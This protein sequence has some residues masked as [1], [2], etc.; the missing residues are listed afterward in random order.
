MIDPQHLKECILALTPADGGSVGN[1]RLFAALQREFPSLQE[2]EYHAAREALVSAGLLLKGKGRGGSVLR[3]PAAPQTGGSE[4]VRE[5]A[6]SYGGT[7][8]APQGPRTDTEDIASDDDSTPA[9]TTETSAP[10]PM[11][12][13]LANAPAKPVR[14]SLFDTN[15]R[16]ARSGTR[17]RGVTTAQGG[18]QIISYQHDDTR[19]NNPEVGL[20]GPENDPEIPKARWAYD[21]HLDPALQFDIGRSDIEALIDD[22][23]RAGDEARM[24]EALKELKR[25]QAPYL[26]WSGK[27]ERT[28]F[29][30]DTV[31]LHVHERIDPATILAAVRK[32][33]E[34]AAYQLSL[35]EAPFD[36]LPLRQALDF[37]KHEH[38][39]ANRLVAGDSLLVMNSL[40]HKESMAGRVQMIYFDP[41]YGIKY[42]SNFQPFVNKRD[43]TDRR[44]QDLT[45]EPEMLKAFRD[46]W[47]LGIH[48]YLTYLRDRLLL[49]RELLHESGSIFVQISDE[50][51]HHVRE[52]MDEVFGS[53]NIIAI[54]IF[55]KT[56]AFDTSFLQ[57]NFDYILWFAK[58]KKLLKF[59]P[60]VIVKEIAEDDLPFF[61]T[62]E[63][64]RI[65][66]KHLSSIQFSEPKDLLTKG[67][68]LSRNP[69]N[70]AGWV[71]SLG[72]DYLYQGEVFRVPQNRHWTTT[73][74]GMMKIHKSFRLIKKGNTL[75]FVRY[76]NDYTTQKRNNVWLDTGVGGF[77]GDERHYVVQTDVRVIS[78]CL[79]MTTDPGDLVF[80][81]TCGS[82]TTAFVA[83]KWGRRWITC[84]TSRVALTL[85]KQRLMTAGFDYYRLR[86]PHEGVRGGFDYETVP[87]I[88]LKAI[89][90]NPEI[91]EIHER[92]HPAVAQALARLNAALKGKPVRYASPCG[93]RKGE[94][95][96]FAAPDSATVELPSGE[97]ALV[98]A[99]LEW[100][101]PFD[102]PETR[103][104][105]Q[106][107]WPEEARAPL[108]AFHAARL[109][110]QRAM[111]DSIAAHA[112]QETLYDK[113]RLDGEK[114][115]ICGPFT[116]EAVP[117]PTVK[118]LDQTRPPLEADC[119]VARSGETSRLSFFRD[120]LLRTGVRGKGGQVLRLAEL[121]AVPGLRYVHARGAVAE[122]G[123]EVVVSFGPEHQALEQRQVAQ[124]LNDA[125]KLR[126]SPKYV[127]FCAFEFDPEAAKDID[128]IAWPGVTLLKAKMNADLLTEDLKKGGRGNQS[129]WLMGQPDIVPRRRKDG[130]WEVEVRGFDYFDTDK[131]E[132]ISG[133]PGNI[134]MWSLDTDY[135]ERSLFPQQVFFPMA[136]DK[137]GWRRLK[138]SIRA[139][140]D[141]E[142]L[143]AYHGTVSLPFKAGKN[144]KAAVRI[145]DDRGI[146]SFRIVPLAE[147]REVL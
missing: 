60:S 139:S 137:D 85:A 140:L 89:A 117:S 97:T 51:L 2:E 42:G 82:G 112:D 111:D 75:R 57:S 13:P 133:G 17:K 24:R 20:V 144:R 118:S 132:L 36:Q 125:E 61:D 122:S 73:Y 107:P 145:V 23:L 32:K 59:C 71:D 52:L 29:E 62:I 115:R 26:N 138:R 58:N 131:G 44:D 123:E 27:A 55:K 63:G 37:Y 69:L 4:S 10:G 19:L 7:D 129:F 33:Q 25:L 34:Q 136:G 134:A 113:P 70:S 109:R 142:L 76:W 116:V 98:N 84:D 5:D 22:A 127:I 108:Q 143:E 11:L 120:E 67:K 30:V 54:I 100:E 35:F 78:R 102:F 56:G 121:E 146:E 40:L 65:E 88:T 6:A 147:E 12:R 64:Q 119:S 126:P 103:T 39:W 31:S 80:D 8:A 128:E 14:P 21:P 105:D 87:H 94:R 95:I 50:N 77:V 53:E 48:S 72:Y 1:I 79:L 47:E 99:L 74:A 114:L 18:R 83:E 43:V 66:R 41:P 15:D 68:L 45:R 124:A 28:S 90:N 106:D 101:A 93:G 110:M 3:P 135:D 130:L 9:N 81:P 38:G 141:E 86:Y 96:D 16:S 104:R 92:L 49:A 91:D 46:T